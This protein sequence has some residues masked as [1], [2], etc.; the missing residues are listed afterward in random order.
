M[1]PK[2]ILRENNKEKIQ[3]CYSVF[4]NQFNFIQCIYIYIYICVYICWS[5]AFNS[6]IQTMSIKVLEYL[7]YEAFNHVI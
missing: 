6:L 7:L 3:I 4:I 5:F 1:V 2:H